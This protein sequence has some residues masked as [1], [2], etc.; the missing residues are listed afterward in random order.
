MEEVLG[1]LQNASEDASDGQGD[2]A[3]L[4]S[5]PNHFEP[6]PPNPAVNSSHHLVAFESD[7]EEA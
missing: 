6:L 2:D 3:I 5:S 7:E 1:Q 4:I